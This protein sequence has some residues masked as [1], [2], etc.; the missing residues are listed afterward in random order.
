MEA[1]LYSLDDAYNLAANWVLKLQDMKESL[2]EVTGV[3]ITVTDIQTFKNSVGDPFVSTL[4]GNISSHFCLQDIASAFSIFDPKKTL[5]VDT[6]K[7]QQYGSDS[8]AVL[9]DQYG[10][11]KTVVS[12]EGEEYEKMGLVSSE[13]EGEWKTLKHYLTRT[14]TGG[15]GISIT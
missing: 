3:N 4:K 15:H 6:S 1:T 8:V 10:G 9:L 14:N 7:Y 2:E 11:R 12:L 13:V 5:N